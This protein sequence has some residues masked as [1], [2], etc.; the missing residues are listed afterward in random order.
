[1]A[2]KSTKPTKTPKPAKVSKKSKTKEAAP[3]AAPQPAESSL[4]DRFA[5]LSP[6]QRFAFARHADAQDAERPR[7]VFGNQHYDSREEMAHIGEAIQIMG[8]LMAE[9]VVSF[10]P[11][12]WGEDWSDGFMTGV[13]LITGALH[14]VECGQLVL[15]LG[16]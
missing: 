9:N 6:D 5:A 1:M 12:S 8:L 3:V 13:R 16:Q 15:R 14:R 10:D 4:L 2:K 7:P 11:E